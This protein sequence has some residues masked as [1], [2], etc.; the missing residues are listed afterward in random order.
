[1][2]KK[3]VLTGYWVYVHHVY[4]QLVSKG[5]LSDA[6]GEFPV[7]IAIADEEWQVRLYS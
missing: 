7:A 3:V 4:N 1:M 6:N 5:E 2:G